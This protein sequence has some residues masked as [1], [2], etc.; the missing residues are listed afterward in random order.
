MKRNGYIIWLGSVI[1][2]AAM[3]SM[4]GVSLAANLF[5]R[6]L[7]SALCLNGINVR[8]IGHIPE[9]LWPRGR[10]LLKSTPE[11]LSPNIKGDLVSYLNVPFLRE[12]DI[13]RRYL[14]SL[15]GFCEKFGK[16]TAVF[17]Y[18]TST[19]IRVIG[20]Y[21]QRKLGIPWVCIMADGEEPE[22][23][24]GLV[25]LS[26]GKYSK[27]V[28][29]TRLHLDGGVPGFHG[30]VDRQAKPKNSFKQTVM[31]AGSMGLHAGVDFLVNAFRRISNKNAELL[32][33]GKGKNRYV[34]DAAY[35]DPRIKVLGAVTEERLDELF[36]L[37][38]IFV[39]SNRSTFPNNR[40][41][42]PS[43]VLEYLS[44]GKPVISTWTEGLSP[45]YRKI[46]TVLENE[47]PECLA[48]AIE[49]V[50]QWDA[51]QFIEFRKRAADFMESKIWDA[52]AKR[53]IEWFKSEV[54]L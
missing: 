24:D 25:F 5:Q 9:S 53:L 44:Y 37:A 36:R 43:K 34:E 29:K 27:S 35:L 30:P 23:A 12:K 10:F 20:E 11:M 49:N 16:P 18:N 41:N 54:N 7:I 46:L 26:W 31:F 15:R 40:N 38:D 48:R 6:S 52:Q 14:K 42:F 32:I 39:N 22:G 8:I 28:Q 4:R 21:A 1:N 51:A 19:P 3:L 45:E 17:S 33:C 2:E 47:T 50:L 13:G